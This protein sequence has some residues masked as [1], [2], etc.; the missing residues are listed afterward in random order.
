MILSAQQLFSDD[1]ALTANADSANVIDLGVPGTPF[2]AAAAL[3]QDVGKGA[4]VP[5]LVQVT[6]DFNTLT[7]LDIKISKGATSALGT[8][9]VSQNILVADLVAGK[10][11]SLDVLPN[12]CDLQFLGI[13]YVVNGSNPTLGTIT[14]GI[15]MGVQT[16]LNDA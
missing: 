16:A 15:T 6:A 9:I 13:E 10:Q 11:I 5:I 8:T 12:D 3:V 2:G 7:S 1:Q 4:K 14:A